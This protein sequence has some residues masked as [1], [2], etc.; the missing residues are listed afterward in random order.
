MAPTKVPELHIEDRGIA[1]DVMLQLLDQI[2]LPRL[3]EEKMLKFDNKLDFNLIILFVE[4]MNV[5]S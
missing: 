1:P 2:L 5:I 4:V 3:I